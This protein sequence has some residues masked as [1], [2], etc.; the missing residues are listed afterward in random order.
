MNQYQI[1]KK[2]LITEKSGLQQEAHN[3]VSFEVARHANRIEIQNAVEKMFNVKV[4]STRTMRVKGKVK[5]RGK[6][7]GKRRD[8]KKAIIT[9]MPGDR[10][11]FF[12]G[13]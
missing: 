1:I 10:I 7:I 6:I 13:V 8:W 3:K 11:E 4:I 12:E 9:L 5:T 2:P